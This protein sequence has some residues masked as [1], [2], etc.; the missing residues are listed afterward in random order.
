MSKVELIQ[1]NLIEKIQE[2]IETSSTIY[3]LTS[4]VMKSGVRL[5]KETLKKAAERGEDIKICAGDYLFV[6]QP[7]ALREL[8]SIH[9]D[10][11]VRL[12]RSRGVS[13]HPKAYLFENTTSGYFIVG[14]SNLSKSALTEGI[15]WNIGL[16]KSVDENVFAESMEEFLKLFYAD[17][18][19]QVNEETLKDYE[20]QY[21]DYHQRHPNLARTWAEA[22]EVE[23]M[24]PL[25][26]AETEINERDHDVIYDPATVTYETIRPR[27]AQV[28]ALERLEAAYEEGYDKAMV[29]MATGLGKTYLAAFFARNFQKALFIAHREEILRQAKKSFQRVMPNKT[30]GI[31]DGNVKEK[32]ADIIFASIFTLSMKKHLEAFAK[33]AFDLIVIDEFHHAAA[34]S[35]Q[36]VLN[37]FQPKF[38]LG[39]TATP[40]RKDNKD[41]YAICDGNVAYKIDFIEAVQRGWLAPFRYYGVYDDTDYSKI[42]WLGN[43]YDEAELLQVQ[44]REEMADKILKAWE[45]Y[46]KTR[47]LVFCSSIKQADF[48]SEYFR[49]RNYRTV[50]LHSKQTDIPRDRAIAMLEKGE[51][52]AIFTVDLFNEGV[53]IPS[54]DTLLFV[55]PTESLTVFT[56]QVGRGLRLYEGKDYCVIIDLIGNYRNADVKLA[57]FD[58]E[59][60]EGKK[61][62]ATLIPTVPKNC[63]IH[64]D[65]R[66]INLLEEM[67]KKRQPRREKLLFDYQQ[68]KQELGYRPTYLQLHLYGRSEAS[69]YKSEFKS[70]IGFLYWAGELSEREKEI[71][72]KYESWLV[73]VERTP[74]TKSYKMVVL[75]AMLQRGSSR[76]H[77]PITPQEAAPFFH[78]YLTE[79]EYRKRIDF[80]DKETKRL[81]VYDEEKV[82]KLI[83][84][85]P[86]T[87]WSESSNGLLSF[88]NNVFSLTFS[89]GPEDEEILYQWTKEICEYRLHVYFERKSKI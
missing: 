32:K 61:K 89:I 38:L 88:D 10:I 48:L 16:D 43:R 11:E 21:H 4:F 64:L 63:S 77:L 13:F 71:F 45:K 15:E 27:F 59:R 41:V 30:F 5:L 47:T 35:Y 29:V 83:A 42:K 18:T 74:M 44:L 40:D 34:R 58:T 6:T 66:V 8:I 55:R 22:E 84:R 51:L 78:R 39:I 33:D 31:Y 62:K 82:S 67:R 60:G 23:L 72:S 37:Y 76:W 57:L 24:L 1:R 20:K 73:E 7:E 86:M 79:K 56:Q 49:K 36:R 12:W 26:K 19:V 9:P 50:S 2:H 70:Y 28:E 75:Q 25:D 54:V 87:K 81:W 85:M 68:L 52:D 65:V 46:K 80:S 69:E 3:I 17:E 14:S 53:D